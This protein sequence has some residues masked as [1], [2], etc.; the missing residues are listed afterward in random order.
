MKTTIE[1]VLENGNYL[2]V[3]DAKKLKGKKIAVSYPVYRGNQQTVKVFTVGDVVS[4][5]DLAKTMK[6]EGYSNRQEYWKTIMSKEQINNYKNRL[7]LLND[8]GEDTRCRTISWD[9]HLWKKEPVETM[10]FECGDADR[11]VSFIELD[12]DA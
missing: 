2:T 8:K 4:E 7:C 9:Y 1:Q 11:Y 12:K 10:R 5:W 6:C 3:A